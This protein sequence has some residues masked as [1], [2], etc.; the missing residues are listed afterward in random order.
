MITTKKRIGGAKGTYFT[1]DEIA[2]L[3]AAAIAHSVRDWLLIS[4]TV[5][6]G[7]R[8]SEAV[9]LTPEDVRDGCLWVG[10]LK[11]SART[12]QP[13][14]DDEREPLLALAATTAPGE[15]LFP[16]T[17]MQF[18]RVMRAS[19][20]RAGLSMAAAHPHSLKHSTCRAILAATG[21][22]Q[23][24]KQYAGHSSIT[25]TLEYTK[26]TDAEASTAARGALMWKGGTK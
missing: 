23:V 19:C 6:H 20:R 18:W 2:T 17:R 14:L 24:V 10:R 12:C 15:R 25:S 21:N 1:P 4:V 7:L 3:L 5:N 22:L 9:S 8:A 13:L 26:P 11:D 16:I